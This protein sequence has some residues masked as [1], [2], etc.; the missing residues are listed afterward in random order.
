MRSND[1]MNEDCGYGSG[2]IQI[3][4]KFF[5]SEFQYPHLQNL[6]EKY[7][8]HLTNTDPYSKYRSLS[9]QDML[10]DDSCSIVP[11]L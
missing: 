5:F 6:K 9:K 11:N 10:L 8:N 3:R 1:E 7:K 2:S 4:R